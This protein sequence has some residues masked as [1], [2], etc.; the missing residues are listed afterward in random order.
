[1]ALEDE[2]RNVAGEIA[3][4][5]QARL[6][7]LEDEPAQIET[8]KRLLNYLPRVGPNFQCPRCWIENE[9][10]S[11]LRSVNTNI[12]DDLFRCDTCHLDLVF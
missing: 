12:D 8:R 7:E 9:K 2:L 10:R 5:L 3:D 6:S 1:M 11:A 4:R